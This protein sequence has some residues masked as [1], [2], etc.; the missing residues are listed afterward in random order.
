M[1]Y[2]LPLTERVQTTL[3]VRKEGQLSACGIN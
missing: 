3:F 2:T 1:V